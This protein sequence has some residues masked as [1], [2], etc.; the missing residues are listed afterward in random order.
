MKY[1]QANLNKL[2]DTYLPRKSMD[3]VWNDSNDTYFKF[4]NRYRCKFNYTLII[5]AIDRSL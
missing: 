5:L 4:Y 1:K 2:F 3:D